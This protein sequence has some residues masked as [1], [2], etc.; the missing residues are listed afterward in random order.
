MG[1]IYVPVLNIHTGIMTWFVCEDEVAER[2]KAKGRWFD[3]AGYELARAKTE[4]SIAAGRFSREFVR[5]PEGQHTTR[6]S[7]DDQVIAM[8]AQSEGAKN[9]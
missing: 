9:G 3:R 4:A 7:V 1:E 6:L 5:W 2:V 8:A